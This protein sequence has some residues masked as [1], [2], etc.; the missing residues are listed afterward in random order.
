MDDLHC[1]LRLDG[2][3]TNGTFPTCQRD[4]SGTAQ[5]IFPLAPITPTLVECLIYKDE[6]SLT[7]IPHERAAHLTEHVRL[8]LFAEQPPKVEN[9]GVVIS[10]GLAPPTRASSASSSADGAGP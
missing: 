7:R 5:E 8:P 9:G 2:D 4:L 10:S 3:Q 6:L 1:D